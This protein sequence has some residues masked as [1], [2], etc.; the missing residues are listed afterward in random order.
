M[1]TSLE[2]LP[3]NYNK[4]FGS[5]YPW[6]LPISSLFLMILPSS[7]ILLY[8]QFNNEAVDGTP[9]IN[10]E[11]IPELIMLCIHCTIGL[12]II[13]RYRKTVE[14]FNA[15]ADKIGYIIPMAFNIL[16][17]AIG[18]ARG[19]TEAYIPMISVT[20]LHAL[21][22]AYIYRSGVINKN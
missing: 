4:L 15:K 14:L 6:I 21:Y 2:Q 5:I 19:L 8:G 1:I 12:F 10:S 16:Y 18:F 20:I 22:L 3:L 9:M 17:V 7:Q 13:I 11:R